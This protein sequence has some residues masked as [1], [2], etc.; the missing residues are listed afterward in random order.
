MTRMLARRLRQLE[1]QLKPRSARPL[2]TI[3]LTSP[4]QPD[5]IIEIGGPNSIPDMRAWFTHD[6]DLHDEN[7][8]A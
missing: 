6:L 7:A 3:H 8:S 1:E 4:G 2:L 5:R